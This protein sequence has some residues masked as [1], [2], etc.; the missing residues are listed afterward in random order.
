MHYERLVRLVFAGAVMGCVLG[1][2]VARAEGG[3]PFDSVDDD[4]DSA[5]QGA[6]WDFSKPLWIFFA[7]ERL[8]APET[9]V[10]EAIPRAAVAGLRPAGEKARWFFIIA[11]IGYLALYHVERDSWEF[12]SSLFTMLMPLGSVV[13]DDGREVPGE[14]VDSSWADVSLRLQKTFGGEGEPRFRIG[15]EYQYA[16]RDYVA[17]DVTDATFT[18]PDDTGASLLN[19]RMSFDTR[20]RGMTGDFVRGVEFE[21]GAVSEKRM[22][23]NAWGPAGALYDDPDA[24]ESATYYGSLEFHHALDEQKQFVLHTKFRGGVGHNLDRLTYMRLGGGGFGRQFDRVGAGSTG[25]ANDGELFRS[26]GVPG[27]F[28]GEFF[29]DS[30]AQVNVELD[31]PAGGLARH[32]VS[33]AY[34]AFQDVQ[35][36]EWRELL[37]FAYGYTRIYNFEKA[38]RLDVGYSPRPEG[39][40]ADTGDVTFTYISKF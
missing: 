9:P 29:T 5:P 39:A 2:N 10:G 32:H 21:I 12:E 4:V 13:Y 36:D 1:A 6:V 35:V 3:T 27:Y 7:Q 31:I 30:F 20:S 34:A 24:Q 26:D 11:G 25:A 28:G 33:A 8:L 15:G 18:L 22:E 19:A 16:Y 40:F 23:W 17:N 37:G 38:I 14:Q